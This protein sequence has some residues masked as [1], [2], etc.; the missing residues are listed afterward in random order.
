M[1]NIKNDIIEIGKSIY[2]KGYSPAMAG[3]ISCKTDGKICIT[4]SST[5]LGELTEDQILIIDEN[6]NFFESN[7]SK[8][9]KPSSEC[10]MHVEIYKKRSDIN[11]IVH[12]HPPYSTSLS[13][14]K[15][16]EFLP[17]LAEPIVLLGSIPRV[18]YEMPSSAE[19]AKEVAKYFENNHAVLMSNHGATVVGKD[20]KE[21]FYKLETLEF[22]SQ[23]YINSCNFPKKAVLSDKNIEDLKQLKVLP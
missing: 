10:I 2:Q 3:N 4:A 17:I 9:L 20:L 8:N 13:I 1:K 18:K 5:C 19:L 7:N 12:A 6:G 14:K 16:Y 22:Y 15:D 11:A 21:A 23:I